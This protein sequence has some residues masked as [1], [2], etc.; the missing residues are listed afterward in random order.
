M[1]IAQERGGDLVINYGEEP[2]IQLQFEL[3]GLDDKAAALM[4]EA[5]DWTVKHWD[6]WNYYKN[7]AAQESVGDKL[8]S[9]N[10]CL[11]AVRHKFHISIQN[12]FAPCLARIAMEQNKAIKFRIAKSRV[13]GFTD[14]PR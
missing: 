4:K 13:D 2:S 1:R 6:E 12:A 14:C 8:A 7:L 11:Q 3:P 9:P 5:R 10:Y